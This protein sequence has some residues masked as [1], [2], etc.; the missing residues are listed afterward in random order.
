MP[1]VVVLAF[2]VVPFL[3]IYAIIQVGHA[4]GAGWT[5]LLLIA[6]SVL[7]A[8]LVKRE[9]RRAWSALQHSLGSGRVPTG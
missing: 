9:G 5:I 8:W 1:A 2:L 7:G 6:D 4:I 3:E